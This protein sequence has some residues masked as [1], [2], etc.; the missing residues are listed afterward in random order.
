MLWLV[1]AALSCPPPKVVDRSTAPWNARDHAAFRRSHV[2]CKEYFP[3]S[4]CVK[5]FTRVEPGTYRV[6][7]GEP[8]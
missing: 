6:I 4:P 5:T 3:K 7:C 8:S 1:L 2:A